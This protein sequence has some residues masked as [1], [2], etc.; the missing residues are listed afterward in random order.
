METSWSRASRSR[1]AGQWVPV[2]DSGY[3][4]LLKGDDPGT[5]Q[6]F[7]RLEVH[8]PGRRR[9][10]LRPRRRQ[11]RSR[12]DPAQQLDHGHRLQPDPDRAGRRRGDDPRQRDL[13]ERRDQHELDLRRQLLGDPTTTRC[14][15]SATRSTRTARAGISLAIGIPRRRVPDA[16]DEELGRDQRQ[17]VTDFSGYRALGPQQRPAATGS[18]GEIVNVDIAGN[19]FL[20][21]HRLRRRAPGSACRDRRNV[22]MSSNTCRARH[23][24]IAID[25]AAAGHGA[26]SRRRPLQPDR[27]QR[28]RRPEL[29]RLRAGRRRAQLVGLQRG[30]EQTGCYAPPATSTSIRGWCSG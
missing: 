18:P 26:D 16:G 13:P 9:P 1:N 8:R 22:G 12:R 17:L 30:P 21:R 25:N 24:G 23:D 7:N 10:R 6:D 2:G 5:T 19:D 14:G 4:I 15:S 28:D 27:R 11:P 29:R 20:A 3:S